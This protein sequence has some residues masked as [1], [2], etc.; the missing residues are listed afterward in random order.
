MYVR[1]IA[2]AAACMLSL[3]ALAA[4]QSPKV[5]PTSATP[6][7]TTG[8]CHAEV[9]SYPVVHGPLAANACNGCHTPV[10]TA[11]HTFSL[12]R[13]G[14]D[15]CLFCHEEQKGSV[16]HK[17]LATG[18]CLDC[19]QPHGGK[20]RAFLKKDS[21]SQACAACHQN[22]VGNHA[23]VHGPVAAGGCTAC[24]NPHA[25]N[26]AKLLLKEA[27]QLCLE[28][29]VSSAQRMET[30]SV[31]HDPAQKNCLLCHNA[32]SA[33]EKM[34]LKL[35]A[36]QL[37]FSCHEKIRNTVEHA[38]TQHGAMVE[39]RT[40]LNCHE[41]HATNFPR[42]LRN[43]PMALCLECHNKPLKGPHGT[44]ADMSAVLATGK[45]LHGP[46][47]EK[48]CSACHQIHGSD[49]FRLLTKEYPP[50]FY[51]PFKEESYALCFS[52]HEKSLVLEP[53]TT[54]L[55]GFRNGD[56]NLHYVHVNRDTKGRTCR[57][58]H[59]T[60]ASDQAKH[61]RDSVPFGKWNMPIKY[62]ATSTG[63]SCAPGCHVP[64]NYDRQKPV[65]YT[66]APGA[67]PASWP[68]ENPKGVSQ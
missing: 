2:P 27:N 30:C 36:Q 3:A 4:A 32:H 68:A 61:I 33:D 24:H 58:C 1:H 15:L 45:S 19:H 60:H 54:T 49:T 31:K 40:C 55:T 65:T 56:E 41:P 34:I 12:A 8:G 13:T 5:R 10:D 11:K 22:V 38:K 18:S 39:G 50:E 26:N 52:C 44:I 59:E 7:C 51:A 6:D 63:G 43:N 9:T 37:C 28:C 25:S 16:V 62:E 64:Y 57:A 35:P 29:H 53:R 48:N 14:K 66:K 46:V 21:V 47:A 20:S 17:P 42:V 67:K 23:V